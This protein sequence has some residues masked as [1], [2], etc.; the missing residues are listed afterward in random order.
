VKLDAAYVRGI[1]QQTGFDGSNLEKVIRL[2]QLLI[3]LHNHPFLHGKLVLKGGTAINLFYLTLARLSVDIDLNYIGELD[4]DRML[5]ERVD[6]AKSV[7]QISLALGYK[8]QRGIDEHALIEWYLGFQN[9][10]GTFDQIQVE[11]NFLMRAC[12]FPPKV[13]LATPIADEKSCEFAVL[14]VEE[15]FAGKIKAMIQRQHP[16]DLYDL[17]RFVRT[18]PAH[19]AGLL[20]K[21]AVLFAST[22]DRDFRT[23]DVKRFTIDAEDIKRLLYPLLKAEDRPTGAEMFAVAKPLLLGV[24]DHNRESGF[25]EQMAAG[26]YAPELLFPEH[27]DIVERIRRH[28]ALLWKAK[29]VADYLSRRKGAK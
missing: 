27:P 24:L 16:R 3:E 25:L 8:V 21:S 10:A 5:R 12:V 6:V 29:N 26:K 14:A 19:E 11:I 20:R 4:R 15:V 18:G 2:E 1:A 17:Y 13:R 7:E 22:M 23:Y 9:H 28:P